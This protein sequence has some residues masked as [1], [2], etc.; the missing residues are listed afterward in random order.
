MWTSEEEEVLIDFVKNHEILYNVKLKEY[1][2]LTAKHI[3][4]KEIGDL[5]NKPGMY[6]NTLI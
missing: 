5:L 1:R 6:I 3:L 4:W 2:Q